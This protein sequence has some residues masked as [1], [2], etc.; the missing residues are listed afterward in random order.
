MRQGHIRH[1]GERYRAVGIARHR[2]AGA[3]RLVEKV[4]G[5]L[6]GHEAASRHSGYP[7]GRPDL[8]VLDEPTNG[9]DPQGIADIREMVRRLSTKDDGSARTIILASHLLNEVEQVCDQVGVLNRGKVLFCGPIG[10]LGKASRHQI[11]T[12]DNKRAM[13]VLAAQGWEAEASRDGL[14]VGLNEDSPARMSQILA[15]SG[16]YLNLLQPVAGVE[17]GFFE[18]LLSNES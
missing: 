9:L 6:H 10:D 1:R 7:P 11:V 4:P 18:L 5:L 13:E 14:L 2:G 3:Y 8:L 15:D 17:T 12:T 16:V